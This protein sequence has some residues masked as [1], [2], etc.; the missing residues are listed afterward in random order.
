MLALYA[1]MKK[2]LSNELA[3]QKTKKSDQFVIVS[4]V[5]RIISVL[6]GWF[7]YISFMWF[8]D[9]RTTLAQT[10]GF[11]S[12]ILGL[13]TVFVPVKLLGKKRWLTIAGLFYAGGILLL[14]VD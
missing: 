4:V 6:F 5:I 7:V 10:I 3:E 13:V 11:T 14:V 1:L 12:L 2:N 8:L 9:Y